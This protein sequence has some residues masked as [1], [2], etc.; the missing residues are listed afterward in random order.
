MPIEVF[1][2]DPREHSRWLGDT[3]GAALRLLEP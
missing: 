1:E 2:T 3:R